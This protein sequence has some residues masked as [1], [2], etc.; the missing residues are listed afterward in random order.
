MSFPLPLSTL[1]RSYTLDANMDEIHVNN[2]RC[3]NYALTW[4][5]Q[6]NRPH[7]PLGHDYYLGNGRNMDD[8]REERIRLSDLWLKKCENKK[9]KKNEKKLENKS[10]DNEK[11][12]L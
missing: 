2:G 4:T 3:P 5:E 8:T 11:N 7:W 6:F 9:G 10:N 12:N 1:Y